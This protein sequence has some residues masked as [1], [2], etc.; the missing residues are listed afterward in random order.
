MGNYADINDL[1][2]RT[3]SDIFDALCRISDSSPATEEQAAGI[4]NAILERAEGIIHGFA[5][6]LYDTP[7]TAT[8]LLQEWTLAL[9]EYELYKRGPGSAIPEKIRETY[10]LTLN[11]LSGLSQGIIGTGGT[12]NR[13]AGT[14]PPILVGTPPQTETLF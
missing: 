13:K 7:M 11:S 10:Q 5:S 8:P 6:L 1:K 12:L 3:G 9:A 14:V 4:A 2:L